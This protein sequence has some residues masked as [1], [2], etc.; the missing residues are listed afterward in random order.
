MFGSKVLEREYFKIDVFD[1]I[2]RRG[3]E[4][5]KI[6]SVSIFC[7][8]KLEFFGAEGIKYL[9]NFIPLS[10]L[11]LDSFKTSILSL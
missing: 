9:Y 10:K 7:F 1:S 6:P 3:E 4:G 2:F 5:S 8:L 11:T